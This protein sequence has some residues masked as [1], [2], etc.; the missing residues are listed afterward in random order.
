MSVYVARDGSRTLIATRDDDT[1][2]YRCLFLTEEQRA[3]LVKQLGEPSERPQ[4]K[5]YRML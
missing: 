5:R 2:Q 3:E 4:R 1:G